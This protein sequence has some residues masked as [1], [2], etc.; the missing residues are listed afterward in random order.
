MIALAWALASLVLGAA[1]LRWGAD[2]RDG[3]DW[4]SC[5]TC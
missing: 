1:A 2:T 3:D 5:R 4:R